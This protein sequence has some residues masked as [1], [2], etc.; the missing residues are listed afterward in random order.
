[1]TVGAGAQR[2]SP[3]TIPARI[4]LACIIRLRRL[5]PGRSTQ[6]AARPPPSR[7]VRAGCAAGAVA[8]CRRCRGSARPSEA[9]AASWRAARAASPALV[10]AAGSSQQAEQ[11]ALGSA[12][13]GRV[14][15]IE[16]SL[17]REG[18]YATADED[19]RSRTTYATARSHGC[20]RRQVLLLSW[21]P[22]PPS[23]GAQRVVAR[24][25]AGAHRPPPVV[26]RVDQQSA[27]AV[28]HRIERA[29]DVAGNHRLAEDAGFEIDDAEAL[30]GEPPDGRRLGITSALARRSQELRTSSET[31]PRK[32]HGVG[33][34]VRARRA[35]PSLDATA[36]RRSRPTARPGPSR[37]ATAARE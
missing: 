15:D 14:I 21:R 10:T 27:L 37:A 12:D 23:R 22:R 8:G 18:S 4:E 35:A 20:G 6:P 13:L 1:M 24:A 30:A 28:D 16:N 34:T 2:A 29:A 9:R 25:S 3:S 17:Q 31:A 26:G 33:D 32:L 11:R 19:S 7:P 36:R 5:L